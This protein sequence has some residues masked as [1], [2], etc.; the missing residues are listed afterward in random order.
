MIA[1]DTETALIAD[2]HT[3]QHGTQKVRTEP[4]QT[5]ALTCVTAYPVTHVGIYDHIEGPELV[6]A[7][8]KYGRTLVFHNAPFDIDVLVKAGVP[9]PLFDL[10][11]EEGRI[12]DTMVLD[13]RKG[14]SQGR[15]D[16]PTPPLWDTPRVQSR[17]LAALSEAYLGIE[18]EKG[19]E[20]LDFGQ[21][22]GRLHAL[23]QAHREYALMDAEVTFKVAEILLAKDGA[24][25]DERIEVQASVAYQALDTRGL[26]IDQ[27]EARRL[28]DLFEKDIGPLQT[29]LVEHGLG[30]W[31]P[32]QGTRSHVRLSYGIALRTKNA[33]QAMAESGWHIFP[34]GKFEKW[35]AFKTKYEVATAQPQFHLHQHI[36]RARLQTLA[37]QGAPFKLTPTGQLSIAADDWK[38]QIP[39][40][41]EDLQVWLKHERLKKIL[42]TY[43]ALYSEVPHVYP[44]IRTTG[45][46]SGRSSYSSP[47]VQNVSKRKHG[48]R[49]LFIPRNSET[50]F[51]KADYSQQE[52][53]TLAQ[54][55]L[56]SGISGPLLGG[57][58]ARLD[59]HTQTAQLLNPGTEPTKADR[60]AAKAVNF[61]VP[62]GLGAKR[63][64]DYARKSWGVNWD[65]EQAKTKRDQFLQ[66]YPDIAEYL[67]L[68]K[69]DFAR[70]LHET[71]GVG[72]AYWKTRCGL[73][74]GSHWELRL[75]MRRHADP[76]VRQA[77]YG[78]ER[79][80]L[81]RLR[82]GF[83]RA[84][85]S[86]TE[87]ANTGF[88]GLA[89]A[90][91]KRAVWLAHR[92]GQRVVLVVHDEIVIEVDR[93]EPEPG[94]MLKDL[95]LQAFID[96]C[97]DV[98][99]YA[100]VELSEPLERWGPATD[101]EGG[102]L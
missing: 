22:R 40:E 14:L 8:L 9:W 59:L 94:R 78:A 99:P 75:A 48:I 46:R 92:S 74:K 63:L 20:R 28:R 43:L 49:S 24:P 10:A 50:A 21:Y 31:Q 79:C 12:H 64:A 15:Y 83:V 38:D 98:G 56:D 44:R 97:P 81:V 23:P 6:S 13:V 35:R 1:I 69:Q 19:P 26:K 66:S 90:V 5:P 39:A 84:G 32:K 7:W 53:L 45:A 93:D 30:E 85:S 72:P 61:G 55:M 42:S 73:N 54:T 62:G 2:R 17:G 91:T 52:L 18:L 80:G 87:S 60:Q 68:H 76:E 101:G 51:V 25:W 29:A 4:Y 100:Q 47:C 89:A 95:M 88:Q 34:D 96:V 27:A 33:V 3:H 58:Q 41:M 70:R 37:D 71:T 102:V 36:I 65:V 82:T 77:Y 67:Q 11:L 16:K 86:F 57:I